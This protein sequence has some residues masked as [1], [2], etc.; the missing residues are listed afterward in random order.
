MKFIAKNRMVVAV[1]CILIALAVSFGLAP[2]FNSL[3]GSRSE[4]VTAAADIAAGTK[5][6][7]SQLKVVKVGAYGLARDVLTSEDIAV[8]RYALTDLY[9]G[10]YLT[11][12]KLS[13]SPGAGAQYLADLDGRKL[14][15]SISLRTFADGLAGKLQSGDIVRIIVTD[16]GESRQTL[17]PPE[18]RYMYLIGI[19]REDAAGSSLMEGSASTS[20]TEAAETLTFLATPRQTEL[21][22]EY[23][24]KGHIEIALV[25]RG[26]KEAGDRLLAQQDEYMNGI[27]TAEETPATE[28]ETDGEGETSEE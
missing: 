8:G 24:A 16:Y 7:K 5:I 6:E 20:S 3:L 18:L 4:V 12:R 11:E 28:E 10:D 17:S 15:F 1:V 21:L 25:Y 2:V 13:D 14:A 23:G 19:S 27:E 22:A 9:R 26:S